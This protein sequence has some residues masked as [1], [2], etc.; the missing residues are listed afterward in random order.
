MGNGDYVV[1]QGGVPAPGGVDVPLPVVW[2]E[3]CVAGYDPRRPGLLPSQVPVELQLDAPAVLDV[4]PGYLTPRLVVDNGDQVIARVHTVEQRN[5]AHR[6]VQGQGRLD[7]LFGPDD[8]G[9]T[10]LPAELGL[11]FQEELDLVQCLLSIEP[12]EGRP[13]EAPPG[14]RR[15]PNLQATAP[16]ALGGLAQ[17]LWQQGFSPLDDRP[18]GVFQHLRE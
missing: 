17:H 11:S 5:H 4:G 13:A 1:Q 8:P 2:V 7:P 12:P 6:R 10:S 18:Q 3:P 15:V 14:R 16:Q 9:H